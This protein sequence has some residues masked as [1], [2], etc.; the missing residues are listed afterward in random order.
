METIKE[1]KSKRKQTNKTMLKSE[2]V[3]AGQL[4]LFSLEMLLESGN[5]GKY[6]TLLARD[7]ST[8]QVQLQPAYSDRS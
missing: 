7:Y 4:E 2:H 6:C 1:R 5:D 3:V 8:Q